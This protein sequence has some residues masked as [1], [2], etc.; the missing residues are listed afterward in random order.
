[1]KIENNILEKWAVLIKAAKDYY[2]DSIPTGLS[3]SEYDE[4]EKKAIEEDKFIVRDYIFE[5]FFPKGERYKNE[6]ITKFKKEKVV[7]SML[8][9]IKSC[10]NDSY[11]LLKY[12]GTSLAIYIDPATGVPKQ[13]VTCGNSSL[14]YGINQSWKILGLGFAPKFPTGIVAVQCEC[15][16]DL[17][18][19]GNLNPERARQKVN[20]II[21]GKKDDIIEDAKS[22]LTLRAYR[23]YCDDSPSGIAISQ[24]DYRDVIKSF[25]TVVS[26]IDGHIKFAPADIFTLEELEKNPG[27]CETDHTKTSTGFFLNDGW[28]QY[29]KKGEVVRGLKF[30]G[31]GAGSDAVIKTTVKGIRWNNQNPKGKDSWS[32]NVLIDPVILHGTTVTKPSAGSV[33]K[34]IK[35]NITPGAEVSVILAN[36]TIPQIGECFKP[37]DG[38]YSWPTCSCGYRLS[39]K[40]IYGS[41]LKCGNPLCTERLARMRKYLRSLDNIS[42][43]LDLN[44][45]LVIDRFKWENTNISIQDLQRAVELN[46][47]NAYYR[48]LKSYMGTELQERNLNLVWKA[49]WIA[50]REIYLGS[51]S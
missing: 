40:D 5:T 39:E 25:P 2:V 19:I 12:D 47:E 45:L 41:N 6:Y 7:G 4:L 33:S 11:Y 35:K 26:D 37:G 24:M 51:C 49:S 10:G 20:G 36:S 23:Y 29:T 15:L 1:M 17:D 8:D 14:G 50:L 22:L 46:D 43:D 18:R 3:D 38:N 16:I 31:A 44:K 42:T 28:I 48:I 34:L 21:N 9:A 13:A 27:Y 32:A 30:A